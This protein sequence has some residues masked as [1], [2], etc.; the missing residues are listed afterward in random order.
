METPS[1]LSERLSLVANATL[2]LRADLNAQRFALLAIA[3]QLSPDLKAA[4]VACFDLRSEQAMAA[5]LAISTQ[6]RAVDALEAAITR[7][8]AELPVPPTDP[9]G[10]THRP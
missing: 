4:L 5:G 2:K 8:R 7:M 1:E 3:D 10:P 9:T 6:D